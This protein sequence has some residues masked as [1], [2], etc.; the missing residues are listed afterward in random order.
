MLTFSCNE[1]E[2]G[3]ADSIFNINIILKKYEDIT[4]V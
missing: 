4:G 2:S 1:M 3:R